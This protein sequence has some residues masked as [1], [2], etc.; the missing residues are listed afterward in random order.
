MLDGVDDNED[1]DKEEDEGVQEEKWMA[2]LMASV[3]IRAIRRY[4]FSHCKNNSKKHNTRNWRFWIM[5]RLLRIL[6][7]VSFRAVRPR[8]VCHVTSIR[9]ALTWSLRHTSLSL[10]SINSLSW[11]HLHNSPFLF[12]YVSIDIRSPP[13]C[14]C[15]CLVSTIYPLYIVS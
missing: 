7:Y 1:E 11:C 10:K 9:K 12:L 13:L 2:K 5:W 6:E 14:N 4:Q 3:L 15:L 8:Q